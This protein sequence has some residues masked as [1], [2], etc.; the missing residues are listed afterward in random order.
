MDA[1]PAFDDVANAWPRYVQAVKSERIHVGALL[2]HTAPLAVESQS[3]VVGVPDD[4]H[5]RLLNS[6]REFLLQHLRLFAPPDVGALSFTVH[7]TLDADGDA[8][9]AQAVDPKKYFE[10]KRRENPVIQALFDQF[11]GELVW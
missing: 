2:Q 10:Q 6:Q 7:A 5:R 3:L 1:R 9:E 11:G 4:F 8:P